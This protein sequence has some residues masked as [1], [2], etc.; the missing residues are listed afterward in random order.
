MKKI[1]LGYNNDF[2]G[3]VNEVRCAD[4]TPDNIKDHYMLSNGSSLVVRNDGATLYILNEHGRCY[5]SSN[6][7][8]S[9]SLT[10][11]PGTIILKF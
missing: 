9:Y 8:Y 4:F 6:R 7:Q 3:Q 5:V 11:E 2:S 1:E 10:Q